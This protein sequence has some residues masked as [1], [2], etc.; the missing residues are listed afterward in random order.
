MSS[1][2]FFPITW[3]EDQHWKSIQVLG[4]LENNRSVYIRIGFRPYFTVRYPQGYSTDLIEEN[5]NFMISQTPVD[6]VKR[7]NTNIYRIYTRNKEDYTNG[8]SFYKKN[9]SGI[10]LDEYQDIKS[11]FFSDRQIYPG[12]WQ[13]ASDL[14]TL[15]Y[16]VTTNTHYTSADL[17]YYTNNIISIQHYTVTSPPTGKIAFFDI[18]AIPSDDVSFPDSEAYEPPDNIFAISLITVDGN[19]TPNIHIFFLT[20][21][22][23][24]K[25]YQTSPSRTVESYSVQ[26]H[27]YTTEKEI[28]TAFFETLADFKPDR[29]VSFNGRRFDLNYI[30]KHV[31]LHKIPLPQF[32]KIVNYTPTF[33]PKRIFQKTPFYIEDNILALS[34]PSISQ[35]DLLDFYRRI[36]PQLPNHKLETISQL[37]LGRGKTGLSIKEMFTK[38]RSSNTEDLYEIIDYSLMDSILLYTL[39][40]HSQVERH[41]SQMADFWKNDP[42]YV[43]SN[44]HED[45]FEDLLRYIT[46]EIPDKISI[47]A[48]L[49]SERMSGVHRNVYVYSLSE[50]YLTFLEQLQDPLANVIVDYFKNTDEGL[51]P[52][53]SGYFRVSFD[54]VE[55]FILAQLKG[56]PIIWIDVNSIAVGGNLRKSSTDMGPVPYFPLL[57]YLPLLLVSGKSWITITENGLLFKRGMSSFVR[58]PFKLIDKYVDYIIQYLVQNPQATGKNISLPTIQPELEDYYLEMK[59]TGDEFAHPPPKK[60]QIIQQLREL[61]TTVSQSWRKIK[62]LQTTGGPVIED[63]LSKSPSKYVPLLDVKFYNKLL[64][65]ALKPIIS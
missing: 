20:D 3:F 37:L 21:N 46:Y 53:K 10:I 4:R 54:L 11:K 28:L 35:I 62:Y 56:V 14:K 55:N 24:T 60:Q 16:N 50:L 39:W 47:D 29:L 36:Y 25:Y 26:I 44:E 43:L 12:S 58:P 64:L 23:L 31:K 2:I 19:S 63:I 51:I 40:N 30:G 52:F 5:H 49:S 42:E 33:Y 34:A 7:L 27:Q 48:P 1:V 45:L 18:E 8:L 22:Q 59:I 61:G 17:E 32:S 41:L 9:S 13:Q 15:M 65:N 6:E 57:D 38:Y